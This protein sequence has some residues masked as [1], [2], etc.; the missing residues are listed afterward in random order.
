MSNPNDAF[1]NSLKYPQNYILRNDVEFFPKIKAL[2]DAKNVRV[3]KHVLHEPLVVVGDLKE[4][5][6]VSSLGRNKFESILIDPPWFEYYARSGGFMPACKHREDTSP[7]SLEEIRN[8]R[9]GEIAA[10][11]SFCFLWC[12]NKHVQQANDCLEHWGFKRIEDICWIK[13]NRDEG[14]LHPRCNYLPYGASEVLYTTKEHLLVGI[15]GRVSRSIDNYLIH[16]NVDSDVIIEEQAPFGCM[17][18]P[19]EA[20]RIIE[21]FCNSNRRIELFGSDHNLRPGWVT[22]GK[23]IS[24]ST[25]FDPEEY[26][27]ITRIERRFIPTTDLIEKLRPRSPTGGSRTPTP[28][29]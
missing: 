25:N 8:L 11:Q 14:H 23:Q 19:V 6:L 2:I 7:W 16:A 28:P 1:R 24:S 9:I 12:G 15:K 5:D 10:D 21:R 18:K 3:D 4:M 17:S 22:V 13:T 27:N 29:G 26:A 20:Y